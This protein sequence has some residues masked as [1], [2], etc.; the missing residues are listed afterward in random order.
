MRPAPGSH[1]DDIVRRIQDEILSGRMTPGTKLDEGALA[2][3][4][5]VSRTPVREALHR[6]SASGL[7]MLRGRHGVQVTQ[8]SVAD[9]LDAYIV[10][11]ELEGLAAKVAARRIREPERQRLR[12]SH[13]A[14]TALAEAGDGEGFYAANMVFHNIIIEACR[15]RLLQEQLGAT[16]LLIAP[17]RYHVTF[18]QG[19]MAASIPQHS[20][21]ME[22]I[23][24][25][26]GDAAQALMT[27]HVNLLGENL[28]DLLHT[29]ETKT[30]AQMN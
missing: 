27:S 21:V 2:E 8:L 19:R 29:I 1:A 4:F 10:V 13:T 16:R 11:A 18:Q 15:N 14:C 12:E 20:E 30:G 3:Q 7:V 23:L 22:A 25:G 9:L 17:Y 5:G 28:A 6:L 24:R 26:D